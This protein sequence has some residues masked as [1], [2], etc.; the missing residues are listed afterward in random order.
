M[1]APAQPVTPRIFVPALMFV[2]V[3]RRRQ[4]FVWS[5]FCICYTVRIIFGHWAARRVCGLEKPQ[6]SWRLIW[7]LYFDTVSGNVGVNFHTR[8]IFV[9]IT[10]FLKMQSFYLKFLHFL[11]CNP[12]GSSPAITEQFLK[13][14]NW[15]NQ[16]HPDFVAIVGTFFFHSWSWGSKHFKS[17]QI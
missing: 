15:P 8:L 14:Q 12:A 5:D 17:N 16:D 11:S 9:R 3:N 7:L 6:R 4:G 10:G 13:D 2:F 1:C